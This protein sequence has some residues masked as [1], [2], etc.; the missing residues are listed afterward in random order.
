MSPKQISMLERRFTCV[1]LS[2]SYLTRSLPRLLT[3]TFSTAVFGRSSSWR[4]GAS[5]YKAAP[6]GPPSSLVQ[7]DADRTSVFMTQGQFA[8]LLGSLYLDLLPNCG[9]IMSTGSHTGP[10]N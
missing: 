1:R 4:F 8:A 3:M 2:H 5:S 7:H 6:K 10:S 9:L